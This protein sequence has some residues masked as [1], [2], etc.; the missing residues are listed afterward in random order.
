VNIIRF[1]RAVRKIDPNNA[2]D[3]NDF[4]N[5]AREAARKTVTRSE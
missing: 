1:P 5:A 3:R 2:K 4:V